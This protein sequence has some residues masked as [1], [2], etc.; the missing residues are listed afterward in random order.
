MIDELSRVLDYDRF[1]F[2][3]DEKQSFLEIIVAEFYF[4]EPTVDVDASSDPDDNVFLECA[5]S[6]DADYIVS[7]DSDLLDIGTYDEIPILTAE[8]L[9]TEINSH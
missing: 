3:E 7:G 9:L 1:G 8:E 2:S 6:V 5:V 4:A